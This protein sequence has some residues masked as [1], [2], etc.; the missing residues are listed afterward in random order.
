MVEMI[1][2]IIFYWIAITLQKSVAGF[3]VKAN[4]FIFDNSK[5]TFLELQRIKLNAEDK[6]AILVDFS[7]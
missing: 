1:T 5:H 3:T 6:W 2:K 7:M 4:N